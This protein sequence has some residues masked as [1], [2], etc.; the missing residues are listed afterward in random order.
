MINDIHPSISRARLLGATLFSIATLSA[1]PAGAASSPVGVWM[2]DTGRGAIEIKD[3]GGQLCGHVV[4]VKSGSDAGGCGKQIIGEVAGDGDGSW[5]GGWIYSPERKKRYNV[6]LEPLNNGSLKVTGFAGVRFLSKTMIW[7]KAP[8][9]LERCNGQSAKAAPAAAPAPVDTVA[10]PKPVAA[11][12]PA[13]A[14]PAPEKVDPKEEIVASAEA[15]EEIASVEEGG[16]TRF[17]LDDGIEIGDVF[18]MKKEASGKCKI[19]AP[20]VDLVVDCDR[21]N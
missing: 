15:P 20:F 6:E 18:S 13:A 7:T 1:L 8:A 21:R 3:C 12:A 14:K 17:N 11:V 9:N 10:A 4:W 2:N 16:E 5:G 19:K